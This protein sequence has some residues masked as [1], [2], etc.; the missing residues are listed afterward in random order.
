MNASQNGTVTAN[1]YAIEG[2]NIALNISPAEGYMLDTLSVT[3][4]SENPVTVEN[5]A[6]TMPATAVSVNAT[7][8][9][10]V[11]HDCN[12]R[13]DCYFDRCSC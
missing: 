11:P 7:F 4:A 13:H 3:D 9:V 8:R 5:N 2:D 10:A 12:R 6:F 1:E